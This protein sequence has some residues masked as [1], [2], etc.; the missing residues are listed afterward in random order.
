MTETN[1]SYTDLLE[2]VKIFEA[3]DTFSELRLRCGDAE[4]DLRKDGATSHVS[5]VKPIAQP[6]PAVATD[7]VVEVAPTQSPVT[8]A[9]LHL[10]KSPMVGTFYA[11]AE[12]GL[13]PFVS[14]GQ[15]VNIHTTVCIIEVMKL[16]NSMEAGV[17]GIVQEILVKDGE[18]VEFGQL[19]MTVIPG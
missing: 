1:L 7:A 16:M 14:V 10:I 8:T 9:G 5:E 3:S 13:P 11:A 12:P 6:L 19:L 4:L 18:N 17:D 15:S 2:I